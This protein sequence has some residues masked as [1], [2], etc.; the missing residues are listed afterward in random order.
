MNRR[1][2]RLSCEESGKGQKA[3][4]RRSANLACALALSAD[5]GILR[6]AMNYFRSRPAVLL[7]LGLALAAPSFLQA[8][9]PDPNDP[10]VQQIK[11]AE[12]RRD[13]AYK[14]DGEKAAMM[15]YR[16]DVE[17]LIAENPTRPEPY[18]GLYEVA[19]ESSDADARP[20]FVRLVNSPVA[21]ERMRASAQRQIARLDLVG[22][23]LD[24][25]FT[26]FDGRSVDLASLRG[27]VVMIDFWATWCGPCMQELPALR[28]TVAKFKER[29][30][31]IV[32]ISLD[33]DRDKLNTVVTREKMTWP[34]FF[35]G[36]G[37][38]NEM[39]V[40]FG[41]QSIPALWLVDQQG[42]LRDTY[43]REDLQAKL[44][45]MLKR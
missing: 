8:A 43:G 11:A 30:V 25:K 34:Q 12:D 23:P 5:G 22:K 37:W 36:N 13:A 24:L 26:A 44:E 4:E 21:P 3:S 31:E 15:Q 14:K 38:K 7:A 28:E 40:R 9:E 17:K 2:W 45:Q 20:L 18:G 10:L 39:A 19:L 41:V 16:A 6:F 27:K 35:D 33:K 1:K 32:G 42:V 29:G